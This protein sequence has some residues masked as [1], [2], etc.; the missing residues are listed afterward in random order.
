[1]LFIEAKDV[2]PQDRSFIALIE[3]PKA[4]VTSVVGQLQQPIDDG[5]VR[6]I[7]LGL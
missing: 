3:K 4:A 5:F 2:R 1:M 7:W 6:G